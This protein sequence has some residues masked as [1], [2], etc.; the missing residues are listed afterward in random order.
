M[1]NPKTLRD[2]LILY[3]HHKRES[4]A[5]FGRKVGVARSYVTSIKGSISDDKKKLIEENYPDLNMRWLVYGEGEMLITHND[6]QLTTEHNECSLCSD[7]DR[8]IAEL[9]AQIKILK[10]MIMEMRDFG[11]TINPFKKEA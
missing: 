4:F 1:E 11:C 7:K 5:E 3:L 10:E 6:P 8:E 2:R 9:K